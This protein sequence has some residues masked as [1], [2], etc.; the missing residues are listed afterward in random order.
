MAQGIAFIIAAALPLLFWVGVMIAVLYAAVLTFRS[1]MAENE[2]ERLQ[3]E[4]E[5]LRL[6][7]DSANRKE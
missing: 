6:R 7:A 3:A 1:D 5:N 2:A 4:N